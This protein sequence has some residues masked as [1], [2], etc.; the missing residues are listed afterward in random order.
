MAGCH[1]L[2]FALQP[3]VVRV[4]EALADGERGALQHLGQE[5]LALA[6]SL[7]RDLRAVQDD[8][9]ARH[10]GHHRLP[11]ALFLGCHRHRGLGLVVAEGLERVGGLAPGAKRQPVHPVLVEVGRV[12]ISLQAQEGGNVVLQRALDAGDVH[13]DGRRHRGGD[14]GQAGGGEQ[15][16]CQVAAHGLSRGQYAHADSSR[17]PSRA[18]PPGTQCASAPRSSRPER[19][20]SR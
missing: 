16:R 7:D 5:G 10:D 12:G 9:L 17:P 11:P 6:G 14:G 20:A 15:Q 19:G 3:V 4:A 1:A 18:G 8:R 2:Q 13:V